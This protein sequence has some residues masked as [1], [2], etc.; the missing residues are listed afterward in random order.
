MHSLRNTFFQLFSSNMQVTALFSMLIVTADIVTLHWGGYK[1][2][3]L[4]FQPLSSEAV[5]GAGKSQKMAF[6]QYVHSLWKRSCSKER[7][8]RYTT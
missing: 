7:A 2:S 5:P 4:Y 1:Q 8:M 6:G 3:A